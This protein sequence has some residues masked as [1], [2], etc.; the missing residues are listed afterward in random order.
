MI[1]NCW[2][3]PSFM[4][5]TWLM[6]P[7]IRFSPICS[8]TAMALV[9]ASLSSEPN[10]SSMKRASTTAPLLVFCTT[11]ERDR[12]IA[13]AA[14][15]VS[16]PDKDLTERS[17][18]VS[19][20]PGKKVFRSRVDSDNYPSQA[21][22]KKLGAMPN[23]VSEILLHGETLEKFVKDNLNLIDDNLRVLAHEFCVE[24]EMLL[25]RV[26]EYRIEWSDK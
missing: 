20:S 13:S 6:T 3:M 8:R 7:T 4:S 15:K 5:S 11:S 16:P 26:L 22:M 10:P 2:A 18:P 19:W 24:P 1:A 23:G 21:L 17:L 9:R 12:A 25:G 14:I